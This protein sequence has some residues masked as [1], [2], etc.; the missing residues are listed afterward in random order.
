MKMRLGI[1]ILFGKT[2]VNNIHLIST[3]SNAHQEVVRLDITMNEIFR[4]DIFNA[5]YL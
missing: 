4:M 2:K 1:A 5:G 3:L